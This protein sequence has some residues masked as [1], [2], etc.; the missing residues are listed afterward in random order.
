MQPRGFQFH[1]QDRRGRPAVLPMIVMAVAAIGLIA[2]FVFVGLA[3][4]IAGL[5]VSACAALWFSIR[6]RLAGPT[7]RSSPLQD[8]AEP[9]QADPAIKVIEVESVRVDRE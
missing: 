4:A 7:H 5:V 1:I 8:Q 2:L 9:E 6:R 3:I